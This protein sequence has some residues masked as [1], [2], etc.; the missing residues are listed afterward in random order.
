LHSGLNE[1]LAQ[2]KSSPNPILLDSLTIL[3]NFGAPKEGVMDQPLKALRTQKAQLEAEISSL[4]SKLSRVVHAI[5]VL[6]AGDLFDEMQALPPKRR[7]AGTL[8]QMAYT[9]LSEAGEP[10]TAQQV[11]QAIHEKF[12]QIIERTSMS[13]QL[14]RLGQ[15]EVLLRDGNLW[16]VN[17]SRR[18]GSDVFY[19]LK[20]EGS[21]V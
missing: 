20:S 1:V 10:M 8:K 12:G 11:L 4:Q 18:S 17:P 15:D 3:G 7:P 2:E 16:V 19:L 9:V 14:S 6:T 21:L 13:P 5:E